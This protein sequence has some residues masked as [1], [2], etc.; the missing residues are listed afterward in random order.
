MK[1]KSTKPIITHKIDDIELMLFSRA[2]G[3][4]IPRPGDFLGHA[5][6]SVIVDEVIDG[7]ITK[8]SIGWD[9][10]IDTEK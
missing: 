6:A 10:L 1:A 7:K 2:R 8:V 3:A 4:I 9:F 5:H